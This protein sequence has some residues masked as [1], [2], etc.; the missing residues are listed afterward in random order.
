[1]NQLSGLSHAQFQQ[2]LGAWLIDATVTV[3][4][5]LVFAFVVARPII[6]ATLFPEG[7]PAGHMDARARWAEADVSQKAVVFL[8]FF[9]SAWVP[10]GFYYALLES[11]SRRAT[12][13]KMALGLVTVRI[14][15]SKVS[16]LRASARYYFKAFVGFVVPFGC[17]AMLP[18]FGGTRRQGA[19]DWVTGVV[20]VRRVGAP[21]SENRQ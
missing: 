4:L 5:S 6:I 9:V 11:S 1:V 21:A 14:D 20:V 8:L 16:F 17:F 15:G 10:S 13:G 2:R 7:A 12:L 19:H 18:A 3:L